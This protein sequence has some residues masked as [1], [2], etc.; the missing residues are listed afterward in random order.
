MDKWID[1]DG[2]GLSGILTEQADAWFYKPNQGRGEFGPPQVLAEKPSL[3]DLNSGWQQLMDLAGVRKKNEKPGIS[4]LY[5]VTGWN[6]RMKIWETE[7]TI[8]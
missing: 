4:I 3:A 2:E 1:L 6:T 5:Q 8:Q 7:C